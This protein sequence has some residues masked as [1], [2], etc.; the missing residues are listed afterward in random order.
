MIYKR[1]QSLF[2]IQI[3]DMNVADEFMFQS[4]NIDSFKHHS[5]NEETGY[6]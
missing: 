2:F 6:M 1:N 5:K 3:L 4:E